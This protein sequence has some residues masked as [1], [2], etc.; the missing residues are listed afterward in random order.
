MRRLL[1]PLLLFLATQATAADLAPQRAQFQAAWRLAQTGVDV[2]ARYP[3]LEDYPLYPYLPYERLRRLGD[4]ASFKEV[5]QFL[6][7][8][9]DSLPGQR[10]RAQ[11]LERYGRTQRF[12]EFLKIYDPAQASVDLRCH[13]WTARRARKLAGDAEAEALA[14]FQALDRDRSD[15]RPVLAHLRA[16]G[17]LTQARL[18]ARGWTRAEQEARQ[19]AQ[20]PLAEKEKRAHHVVH[21]NGSL[22]EL[23][24]AVR[25]VYG[26]IREKKER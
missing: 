4:K 14:L 1:S 3:G 12:E 2:G 7:D 25:R 10:L 11:M 8:H 19:R 21:N 26:L 5:E 22:A 15:C 18:D 6:G 20:W 24:E 13:A 9:G 17:L 23:A 16:S